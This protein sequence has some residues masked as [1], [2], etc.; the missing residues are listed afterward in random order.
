M[1]RDPQLL[2]LITCALDAWPELSY[3]GKR[4][5]RAHKAADL[6]ER[7]RVRH[8][9]GS[10]YDVD[11]KRCDAVLDNCECMDH[12]HGAP[13]YPKVGKLCKHRLAARMYRAW[14]GDRNEQLHALLERFIGTPGVTLI[15][16]WDYE[17]DR[18]QVVGFVQNCRRTRWPGNAGIEFTWPQLRAE[19]GSI[20]WGLTELPTKGS[21]NSYE[22]FYPLAP[23]RGIEI[24]EHTMHVFGVN[25]IMVE[26]NH[27]RRLTNQFTNEL[28]AMPGRVSLGN[29]AA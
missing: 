5:S 29:S 18:R 10:R 26:R 23:G 7:G 27:N 24:N 9:G 28:A 2:N 20:D 1:A 21:G 12:E 25:E 6:I 19:V 15:V 16:E 14:Q 13:W 8:L 17:T 3:R 11:G 4:D 22:Y